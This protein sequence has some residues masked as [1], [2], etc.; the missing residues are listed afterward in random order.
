M[1]II[2]AIC[3]AALPLSAC[4]DEPT[5]PE[6]SENEA[7]GTE[8]QGSGPTDTA[9]NPSTQPGLSAAERPEPTA[10]SDMPDD[11]GASKVQSF[12]GQEATVPV[13]TEVA[14]IAGPSSDRWIY[15]DTIVTQDFDQSR[16]KVTMEKD[17][18]VIVSI[19]CG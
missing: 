7:A 1:R 10:G 16:L 14:R 18:D 2:T 9:A 11:C 17:T 12:I 19:K 13:R 8:A 3:L 15:P 6:V 4:T 5:G